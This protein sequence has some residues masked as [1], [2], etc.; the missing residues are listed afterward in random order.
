LIGAFRN[1]SKWIVLLLAIIEFGSIISFSYA[2]NKGETA[3]TFFSSLQDIP[4]M[5]GLTELKEQSFSFDKPEG[6]ITEAAALMGNLQENQVLYFYQITLPQ[7][8]WGKIS[9]SE[10]FRNGEYLKISFNRDST[11]NMVKIMIRPTR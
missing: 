10:F 4:V 2:D 8:G 3:P 11:D 1:W 6:E 9:N 7:F 5:P